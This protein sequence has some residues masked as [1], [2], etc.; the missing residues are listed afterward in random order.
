MESHTERPTLQIKVP[1]S[2]N[3]HSIKPPR[4]HKYIEFKPAAQ[5]NPHQKAYKI[6]SQPHLQNYLAKF[7]ELEE[8]EIELEKIQEILRYFEG[9]FGQKH[10]KEDLHEYTENVKRTTQLFRVLLWQ[11]ANWPNQVLPQNWLG[12]GGFTG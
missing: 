9:P 6:W 12:I 7:N 5:Q 4:S 10:K 1:I 2:T 11:K 8:V 3:N